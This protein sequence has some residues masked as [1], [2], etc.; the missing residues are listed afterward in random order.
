MARR[1]H[2]VPNREPKLPPTITT[3]NSKSFRLPTVS[4]YGASIA[5]TTSSSSTQSSNEYDTNVLNNSTMGEST[6]LTAV[7]PVEK[8]L[9]LTTQMDKTHKLTIERLTSDLRI[10]IDEYKQNLPVARFQ[11]FKS[12][13]DQ[14]H[15]SKILSNDGIY[16]LL[17]QILDEFSHHSIDHFLI[18]Y[19][20]T[21]PIIVTTTS[22]S[23]NEEESIEE[24]IKNLAKKLFDTSSLPVFNDLPTF[25]TLAYRYLYNQILPNWNTDLE[26]NVSMQR[27]QLLDLFWNKIQSLRRIQINDDNERSIFTL[28]YLM[29]FISQ[30]DQLM[31]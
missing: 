10:I 13:L 4:N 22:T 12:F 16:F 17:L 2:L 19:H 21:I 20:S 6:Y 28:Y 8:S 5:S 11:T 25:E 30:S 29:R 26:N 23:R 27:V 9:S 14:D 7:S 18:T 15:S 24:F 3:T 31:I 1:Q